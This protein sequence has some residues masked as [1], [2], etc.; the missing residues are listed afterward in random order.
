MNQKLELFWI[1]GSPI[2]WRVQL[3][4]AIFEIDY[5]SHRLDLSKKEQKQPYY[6]ALNPRGK[7]PVLRHGEFIVR[8]S[9]AILVYL[10]SLYPKW[11]LFGI[12]PQNKAIIWQQI[13]ETE[14]II[15]S[16]LSQFADPILFGGLETKQ[17]EVIEAS[18]KLSYEFSLLN[19]ILVNKDWLAGDRLSAADIIIYPLLKFAERAATRVQAKKLNLDLLPFEKKYFNLGKWLQKIEEIPG[20]CNTYPPHW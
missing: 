14:N 6:L 15:Q 3:A 16:Y 13:C 19:D 10:D 4:L 11:Q 20:V 17:K 18:Q 5:I 12:A 9:V 1:S 7:V 8:E 2:A